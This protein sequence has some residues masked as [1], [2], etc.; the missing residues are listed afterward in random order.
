MAVKRYT[1]IILLLIFSLFLILSVNC[2]QGQSSPQEEVLARVGGEKI[3]RADLESE[4]KMYPKT[5]QYKFQ[6]PEG[7]KY[8]LRQIINRR[9]LEIAARSTGLDKEPQVLKKINV[10]VQNVLAGEFYYRYV[11]QRLWIPDETLKDYYNKHKDDYKL[12]ERRIIKHILRSDKASIDDIYERLKKGEKFEDLASQ[13]SQDKFTKDTGGLIGSITKDEYEGSEIAMDPKVHEVAFSINE[14]EYSQ[15]FQNR[16]GYSI[17]KVDKIIPPAPS[18]YEDV[19]DKVAKDV[20]V[21]EEKAREYYDKNIE[22]FKQDEMIEIRHGYFGTQKEASDA[23]LAIKSGKQFDDVLSSSTMPESVKSSGGYRNWIKRG[24]IIPTVGVDEALENALFALKVG[25]LYGPYKSDKGWHIFQIEDR[26]EA[27]IKPYEEVKDT[28]EY[29]LLTEYSDKSEEKAF[30]DMQDKYKVI[31][32]LELGSYRMMTPEQILEEAR[33]SRT[34]LTAF[35]AYRAFT[36]IYPDHPDTNK[37]LF[38]MGFIQSEQLHEYSKAQALFEEYLEKYPK[39]EF[40][41]SAHW[42]LENLK[43]G[44]PLP[45]DLKSKVEESGGKIDETGRT[46]TEEIKSH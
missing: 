35:D 6:N 24:N 44:E 15:P 14:G 29:Q 28:I 7:E 5:E 45:E 1:F 12:P 23:I 19:V 31:N 20:A 2:R 22:K 27:G 38:L 4:I 30:L 39:G 3:T 34:P 11:K 8:L 9:V 40:A 37:A 26:K 42:M 36:I 43:T 46:G 33:N 25:D 17:L 41:D 13:L 10:A 16:L 32:Y 21:P 18:P